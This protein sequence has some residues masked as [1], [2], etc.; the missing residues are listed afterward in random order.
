MGPGVGKWVDS[1]VKATIAQRNDVHNCLE[2][3]LALRTLANKPR[4]CRHEVCPNELT[5]LVG[6]RVH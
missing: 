1:Q 6:R 5:K 2:R 3:H 4:Y